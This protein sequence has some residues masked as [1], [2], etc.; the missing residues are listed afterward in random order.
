[1]EFV[2]EWVMF[3][4]LFG[5]LKIGVVDCNKDGMIM[6]LELVVYFKDKVLDSVVE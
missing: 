6:V 3:K 4:L 5:V 2:C 1:M